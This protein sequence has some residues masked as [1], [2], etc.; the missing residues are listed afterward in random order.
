MRNTAPLF[1]G[2]FRILIC[3]GRTHPRRR[4]LPMRLLSLALFFW[5]IAPTLSEA[6][7]VG[8]GDDLRAAIGA[9]GPGDELVLSGG[10]YEFDSR[11]NIS[12]VGESGRPAIIRAKSGETPVIHM[13]TG[14][15]N[16]IEIQGSRHLIVRGLTFT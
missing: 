16:V 7:E 2:G 11:F 14:S 1:S 4:N 15:Q 12:V 6:A 13:T 3:G 9:L 5:R 8:P 10:T